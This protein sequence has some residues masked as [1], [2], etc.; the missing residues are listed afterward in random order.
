MHEY[1]EQTSPTT[2]SAAPY[3]N[4]S[5]MHEYNDRRTSTYKHLGNTNASKHF[6]PN[7][8]HS[9]QNFTTHSHTTNKR[10]RQQRGSTNRKCSPTKTRRKHKTR[11]ADKS[12]Q[13]LPVTL[14]PR[15]VGLGN[16]AS[17]LFYILAR[18]ILNI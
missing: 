10:K 6:T 4:I 11:G 8:C 7:K 2:T 18:G 16:H 3:E 12:V 1:H 15:F 17:M 5:A 13:L 14:R 9:D